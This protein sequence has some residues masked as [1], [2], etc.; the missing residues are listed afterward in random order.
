MDTIITPVPP[1]LLMPLSIFVSPFRMMGCPFECNIPV[2]A[3]IIFCF[4]CGEVEFHEFVSYGFITFCPLEI[5]LID[6]KI[7]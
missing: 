4:S 6:R 1:L 7:F 3:I 5:R 2:I